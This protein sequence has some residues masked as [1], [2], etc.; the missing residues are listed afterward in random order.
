LIVILALASVLYQFSIN[1]QG[2]THTQSNT[3]Q[4][5]GKLCFP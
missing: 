3:N 2:I 5:H 1:K 4:V